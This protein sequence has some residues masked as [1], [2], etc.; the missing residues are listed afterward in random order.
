MKPIDQERKDVGKKL[1]TAIG[2]DGPKKV[3]AGEYQISRVDNTYSYVDQVGVVE[4]INFVIDQGAEITIEDYEQ[5]L[6]ANKKKK[7]TPYMK[8]T[9]IKK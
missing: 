5:I 6:E 2:P 1:L 4:S 7:R 3:V 8:V 9:E